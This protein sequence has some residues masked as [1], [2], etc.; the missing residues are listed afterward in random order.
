MPEIG[1]DAYLY[2]DADREQDLAEKMMLLYKDETLRARL[3]ANGEQ[4]LALFSW[5]VS[6]GHMW[7]CI[8]KA[9][10]AE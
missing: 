8:L 7:Q 2:F 4:R 1:G 5:D 3:V 9:A 10:A 6:A